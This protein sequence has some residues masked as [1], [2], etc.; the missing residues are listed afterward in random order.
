[1]TQEE[2]KSLE[3]SSLLVGTFETP[4]GQKCLAHLEKVFI[5][6]A[7]YVNGNTFEQTAYRQGQA[8]VIKQII[9]E[10]RNG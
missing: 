1:M 5:D 2:K 7:V 9:K 3:I 8:D 4:I 6:R 10:V